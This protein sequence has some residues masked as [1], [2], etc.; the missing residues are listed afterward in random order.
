M[1]QEDRN[2]LFTEA[3][4]LDNLT[5]LWLP[6]KERGGFKE[7]SAERLEALRMKEDTGNLC[8]LF[9]EAQIAK[10]AEFMRELAANDSTRIYDRKRSY[11]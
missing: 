6:A 8:V 11:R 4:R 1:L 7:V 10:V 5:R 9:T 2:R 3:Y